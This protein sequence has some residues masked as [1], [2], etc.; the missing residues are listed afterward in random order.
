MRVNNQYAVVNF[1]SIFITLHNSEI[2]SF[3]LKKISI[4]NNIRKQ[5]TLDS[6]MS[7]D[8]INLHHHPN[9]EIEVQ[10]DLH[11]STRFCS[12]KYM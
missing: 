1:I 6:G 12:S 5:H 2:V 11:Y 7:V 8:E 4:H 3:F 10:N 9:K